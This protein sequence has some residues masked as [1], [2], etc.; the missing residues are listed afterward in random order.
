MRLRFVARLGPRGSSLQP[1]MAVSLVVHVAAGVFFALAPA[2][3]T[4]GVIDDAFFVTLEG[5]V[6]LP[7]AATTTAPPAQAPAPPPPEPEPEPE[8]EGARV[9]TQ[10]VVEVDKP[11]PAE[12]E[13]KPDPPEPRPPSPQTREPSGDETGG[14]PTGGLVLEQ[15]GVGIGGGLEMGGSELSWYNTAIASALYNN[16]RQPGSSSPVPLQV[17]VRFEILRDG[18]VRG[19]ELL[20]SSGVGILDRSVLRAVSSA[21]P[22]PPIPRTFSGSSITARYLFELNPEE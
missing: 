9:E 12:T 4:P 13:K 20:Q 8:P 21:S 19:V 17:E 11:P 1:F 14:D 15:G 6:G 10:P 5:P 7:A 22:L 2:L 16:W 3:R 18:S